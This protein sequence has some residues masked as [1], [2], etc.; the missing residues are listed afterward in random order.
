[1]QKLHTS[2]IPGPYNFVTE[3]FSV[4]L[5]VSHPPSKIFHIN[6]Y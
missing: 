4:S 5:L 3:T 1:M 2:F 6:V